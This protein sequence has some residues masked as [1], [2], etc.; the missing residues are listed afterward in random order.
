MLVG[1]ASA[2]EAT[3]ARTFGADGVAG[4]IL[5]IHYARI[6][7]PGLV[8]HPD[9]GF[10]AVLGAS[11]SSYLAGGAPD[12]S[13]PPLPA[14]GEGRVF[15][16][17]GAKS[18]ILGYGKLTRLNP[19]G[20]VD[21]SFG[22]AGTID[23]LYFTKAV[24]ELPSGTIV[25]VTLGG[26]GGRDW[27]TYVGV[28]LLS[29]SGTT[30]PEAVLSRVVSQSSSIAE[31]VPTPAGGALV[32]GSGFMLE[33]GPDG[34]AEN[35]FG[36]RG[37]LPES[38]T[39]TG[40][41]FLPDGSIAAVGAALSGR[42]EEVSVPDLFHLT[43]A[44]KPDGSFGNGGVHRLDLRRGER[45]EAVAWNPDGSFVV[46]GGAG[47]TA[48]D[49]DGDPETG[50]GRGGVL[51]LPTLPGAAPG[52]PEVKITALARRPDGSL[53]VAGTA[54]PR[55]TVAFVTA[56][57]PRGASLPSFG[58]GGAVQTREPMPAR[59]RILVLEPLPEGGL[60]AAG[61]SNV[62]LY[63]HPILARYAPDGGLDRSFGGGT[64]YVNLRAGSGL[65]SK[66]AV[67]DGVALVGYFGEPGEH[68]VM[69]R[70]DDGARVSSFGSRGELSLPPDFLTS[71]VALAPDGDPVVLGAEGFAASAP[72]EILRFGPDG[73]PDRS[74]GHGGKVQL[75]APS[76]G[77][78]SATSLLLT[79]GGRFLVGG[80]DD[81]GPFLAR[82]LPDGVPDR[83]FG[84]HGW[85]TV[86]AL[87]PVQSVMMARGGSHVYLACTEPSRRRL[88]LARFD[89]GGRLDKTFGH[90]GIRVARLASASDPT[91]L[92]PVRRGV[93]VAFD[94]GTRPLVSF[95]SDGRVRRLPV[96]EPPRRVWDVSAAA[97][98]D[99]LVASWSPLAFGEPRDEGAY[100]AI[101][102]LGD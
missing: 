68:L 69:V 40:A 94:E 41:R 102:P 46:G 66:L 90:G 87:G 60:L 36:D 88:L 13:R 3:E 8:A 55:A 95:D 20:S 14:P 43:A 17:G 33:L 67:R 59:E 42:S 74:F 58:D 39:L 77:P 85:S 78:L 76:G 4:P 35:G 57:S 101:P 27:R 18:F 34:K 7:P 96:S 38:S 5:G 65:A 48:F 93:I 84:P 29:S 47:L 45:I 28:S 80:S 62:G 31:I 86:R 37:F 56:V 82:L 89:A 16:A 32:V 73:R 26:H 49:A 24:A 61:Q 52:D 99:Q 19:D 83:A 79:R 2:D 75:R 25:A 44:G 30:D 22:Q 50:F 10:T 15:P 23:P 72:R 100:L 54:A 63:D 51:H 1:A 53:L 98:G 21:G 11:V 71:A 6:R 70:T 92:V 97:A 9:G 91:A 12:P 64:G 81:R